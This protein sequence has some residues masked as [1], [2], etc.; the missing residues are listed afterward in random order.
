MVLY[1]K[2]IAIVLALLFLV[3][4]G[5]LSYAATQANNLITQYKPDIEKAVSSA[6]QAEVTLGGISATAFPRTSISIQNVRIRPK[7]TTAEGLQLHNAQLDIALLPLLTGKL[8]VVRFLLDKPTLVFSKAGGKVTVQGLEGGSRTAAT[9]TQT[10]E[11]KTDSKATVATGLPPGLSF[12]L[13]EFLLNKAHITFKD[14][15]ASKSYEIPELNV[16]AAAELKGSA[17]QLSNVSVKTTISKTFRLEVG[18]PSIQ[19]DTLSTALSMKDLTLSILGGKITIN[20]DA[21]LKTQ[22]GDLVVGSSALNLT[23]L[24]TLGDI[25]PVLNTLMP[26]GQVQPEFRLQLKENLLFGTGKIILRD[27][28][29]SVGPARAER[30][31]GALDIKLDGK[32]QNL[33]TQGLSLVWG[34]APLVVDFNATNRPDTAALNLLQLKGFGGNVDLK[35]ELTQKT[36]G[37]Q[38]R[39]S[40]RSLQ[41]GDL[42]AVVSPQMAA[43]VSGTI[44]TA[45]AEV[46]GVLGEQLMQNLGG[47]LE[48]AFSDGALKGVNIAAD[49]LRAIKNLPFLTGSLDSGVNADNRIALDSK[50]TAI[51][52]LTATFAIGGGGMTTRNL[53]LLST[54]F[55][56]DAQGRLGFDASIDLLADIL[57][58]PGLSAFLVAKTSELKAL[59]NAEQR[60]VLPLAINGKV[61]QLIVLPD[62]PKIVALATKGALKEKAAG[63]LQK[64]L[65]GEKKKG[66]GLFGF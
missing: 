63:A 37:F 35:G 53:K 3:A 59:Q 60:L 42:A 52:K 6:L 30:I 21:N 12:K 20:A 14:L 24:Q 48:L 33:N 4:A 43:I 55:N 5:L 58:E 51:K 9:T 28:G 40:A 64:I 47:N 54:I 65:G 32:V 41:L 17:V 7:Q 44:T 66:S 36:Q 25:F 29:A 62:L 49:V 23:E 18:A 1:M 38:G 19:F 50:D 45:D 56:L 16:S 10:S 61:P 11:D 8:E 46:R 27:V 15:D 57:F 31:Q 22:L 34:A 39:L 26:S 2:K 13:G